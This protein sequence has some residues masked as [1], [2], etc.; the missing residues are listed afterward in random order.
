MNL[1]LLKLLANGTEQLPPLFLVDPPPLNTQLLQ[2]LCT[3]YA[4][5]KTPLV[6]IDTQEAISTPTLLQ[7]YN[8]I[9]TNCQEKDDSPF[10]QTLT[11]D[12]R[13]LLV[14]NNDHIAVR[15]QSEPV[16]RIINIF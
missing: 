6:I 5:T 2:W 15:L 4:A 3:R 13:E 14:Q 10:W 9:I 8:F 12:E 7:H 16:T 11:A 1:L